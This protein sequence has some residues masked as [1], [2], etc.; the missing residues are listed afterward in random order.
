MLIR[1]R[2]NNPVAV[3]QRRYIFNWMVTITVA[4]AL[5]ASISIAETLVF[6]A[7]YGWILM[8]INTLAVFAVISLLLFFNPAIM[9]GLPHTFKIVRA[10]PET[11]V[12]VSLA[13]ELMAKLQIAFESC[14]ERKNYLQNDV[15]LKKVARELKTQPHVLSAFLNQH[16]RM[17]F[18]ELIN[19][20]RVQ[21][22][23]AGMVKSRCPYHWLFHKQG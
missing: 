6:P 9:Y 23:K 18:N 14:I 11:P 4:Y 20:Y 17:H 22:I 2:T 16:Y 19:Y 7:T 10:T 1:Y 15:T 5:F 21:Y 3:R 8:V 13:P 12:P